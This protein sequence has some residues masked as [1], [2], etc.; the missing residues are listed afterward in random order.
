MALTQ[1]QRDRLEDLQAR[2][3]NGTLSKPVPA[4]PTVLI[5]RKDSNG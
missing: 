4:H 3:A 5:V 2:K 1:E